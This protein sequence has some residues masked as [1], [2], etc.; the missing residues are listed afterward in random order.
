MKG[1]WKNCLQ[2]LGIAFGLIVITVELVQGLSRQYFMPSNALWLVFGFLIIIVNILLI[3]SGFPLS[4]TNSRKLGLAIIII[5][6]VLCVGAL[7]FAFIAHNISSKENLA[8]D[9]SEEWLATNNQDYQVWIKKKNETEWRLNDNHELRPEVE[10]T[11]VDLQELL[12]DKFHTKIS[13]Y[14]EENSIIFSLGTNLYRIQ[15]EGDKKIC[16]LYKIENGTEQKRNLP[17]GLETV[18]YEDKSRGVIITKDQIRDLKLENA[19]L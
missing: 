5:A 7:I 6:L 2:W 10:L 8:K 13:L 12:E 17:N 19:N 15:K 4:G 11:E 14:E 1:F 9:L 18:F 3:C 16:T